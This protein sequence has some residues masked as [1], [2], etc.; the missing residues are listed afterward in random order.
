MASSEHHP[1]RARGPRFL[2]AP[3]TSAGRL[4]MGNKGRRR[5]AEHSFGTAEGGAPAT[6]PQKPDEELGLD[7]L[8][9]EIERHRRMITKEAARLAGLQG[10]LKVLE[11]LRASR[12]VSDAEITEISSHIE[13]PTLPTPGPS[14]NPSAQP[15]SVAALADIVRK[16]ADRMDACERERLAMVKLLEERLPS[17]D[18]AN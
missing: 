18:W 13:A 16:I 2:P 12:R 15:E 5:W 17:K 9:N 6:K 3:N 8:D 1:W 10:R 4:G 7:D 11:D 14:Y